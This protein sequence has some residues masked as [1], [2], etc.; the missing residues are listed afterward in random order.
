MIRK[1]GDSVIEIVEVRIKI[2]EIIVEEKVLYFIYV[3][4]CVLFEM[5]IKE[6][7]VID[8]M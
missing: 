6:L 2:V 8:F 3:C 1:R 4:I 5:K 7:N